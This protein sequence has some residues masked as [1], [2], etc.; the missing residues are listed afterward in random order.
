[1]SPDNNPTKIRLTGYKSENELITNSTHIVNQNVIQYSHFV[2][3]VL[4]KRVVKAVIN[5][6]PETIIIVRANNKFI[7]RISKNKS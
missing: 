6:M 3:K 5:S 4:L 2:S 1:M 7:Y